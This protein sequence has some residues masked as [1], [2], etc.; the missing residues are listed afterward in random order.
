MSTT[1][2]SGRSSKAAKKLDDELA[3]S[4]ALKAGNGKS[5]KVKPSKALPRKAKD[6]KA[7]NATKR[8]PR[9]NIRPQPARIDDTDL[10]SDDSG[11]GTQGGKHQDLKIAH[12][13]R[14]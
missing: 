6:S 11:S 10:S 1:T 13:C 7:L 12:E 3:A 2:R 5:G 9:V 14:N 8:K 4:N